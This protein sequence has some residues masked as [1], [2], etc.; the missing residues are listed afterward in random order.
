MKKSVKKLVCL[1]CFFAVSA[2]CLSGCSVTQN[3]GVSDSSSNGESVSSSAEK[4]A[5][6]RNDEN[7]IID[8]KTAQELAYS[9]LCETDFSDFG[10]EAKPADFELASCELSDGGSRREQF[11]Y[12]TRVWTVTYNNTNALCG[13]VYFDISEE[14][15]ALLHSGYQGD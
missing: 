5:G 15:G 1:L 7:V 4:A 8:E 14:G 9:A 13:S 6:S 3:E 10:F 11:G 12:T 2:F